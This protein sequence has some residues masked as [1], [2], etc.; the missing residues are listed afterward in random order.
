MSENYLN[1]ERIVSVNTNEKEDDT[2]ALRPQS[3]RP[4]Y[5][6]SPPRSTKP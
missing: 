2:K 6:A 4:S 3:R 5:S 1:E